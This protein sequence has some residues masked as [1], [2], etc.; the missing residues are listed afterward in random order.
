VVA[1][2]VEERV[3]EATEHD[4]AAGVLCGEAAEPAVED[5]RRVVGVEAAA[6]GLRWDEE[7]RRG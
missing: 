4:A 5:E 6:V 3:R 7:F 2:A 1:A